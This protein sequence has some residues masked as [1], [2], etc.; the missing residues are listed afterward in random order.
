MG[1]GICNRCNSEILSDDN[2][3]QD[4]GSPVRESNPPPPGLE[5]APEAALTCLNCGAQP[6]ST[7]LHCDSCGSLMSD[8][9]VYTTTVKT[10]SRIGSDVPAEDGERLPT[11]RPPLLESPLLRRSFRPESVE[12]VNPYKEQP[13]SQTIVDLSPGLLVLAFFALTVL[14]LMDNDRLRSTDGTMAQAQSAAATNQI[15]QAI[16]LLDRLSAAKSGNLKDDERNLLNDSLLKRSAVFE[17]NGSIRLA[18]ADLLR[19]TPDFAS[20]A[21]A[22]Q[23]LQEYGQREPQLVSAKQSE[24][25]ALEKKSVQPVLPAAA[26]IEASPPAVARQTAYRD[27]SIEEVRESKSITQ[28]E[29]AADEDD[30]PAVSDAGPVTNADHPAEAVQ[31][32]QAAPAPASSAKTKVKFSDADVA[33]Y[34]KLLAD[35]FSRSQ[36]TSHQAAS[37]STGGGESKEPPSLKEWLERGRPAF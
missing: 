24:P 9:G 14:W 12:T 17:T 3:C 15:D 33:Q 30:R 10:V 6:E 22:R 32:R 27:R 8:M 34:N 21:Q 18:M 26:A 11:A 4:C 20:Y 28:S 31:S 2:F 29:R 37:H 16:N 7:C 1:T 35:Y 13:L 23:K 19:I 36:S 25:A 5:L